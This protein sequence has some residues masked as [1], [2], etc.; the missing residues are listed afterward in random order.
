MQRR[1]MQKDFSAG[2]LNPVTSGIVQ[3]DEDVYCA[4]ER[5][6]YEEMGIKGVPLRHIDTFYYSEERGSIW[7]TLYDCTYDGKLVLEKEEVD[8]VL[9]MELDE[10]QRIVLEHAKY[11][12]K[13]SAQKTLADS[14]TRMI[15]GEDGLKKAKRATTALF[16]E[17]ISQ[18]EASDIEELVRHAP[19][20]VKR[21]EEI[22][23]QHL[24]DVMVA[25]GICKSK[26]LLHSCCNIIIHSF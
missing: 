22:V 13:R 1:S 25:T 7:G 3:Y 18:L 24:V 5:E 12:E 21:Y 23:Q 26:G 11:P 15:H 14:V 9:L 4:A 2:L 19:V 6:L 20:H 8:D 16:S 17:N 10:I